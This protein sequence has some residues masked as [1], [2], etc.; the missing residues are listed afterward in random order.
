MPNKKSEKAG[1]K[2]KTYSIKKCSQHEL[3]L[4]YSFQK[5]ACVWPRAR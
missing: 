1:V 5:V 4:N 3:F 2:D